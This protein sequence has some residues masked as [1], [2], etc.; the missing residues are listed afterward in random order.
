M[1]GHLAILSSA[2]SDSYHSRT[3]KADHLNKVFN[4]V[5]TAALPL[6]LPAPID[7]AGQHLAIGLDG[8][9]HF[10]R[11]NGAALVMQ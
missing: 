11:G 5:K 3:P 6:L 8:Q 1:K 7:P 2:E 4:L 9:A 10:A